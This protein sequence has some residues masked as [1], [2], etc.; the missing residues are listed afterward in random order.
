MQ[1]QGLR[2]GTSGLKGDDQA[3]CCSTCKGPCFRPAPHR[4]VGGWL[5]H[6]LRT[7]FAFSCWISV[8]PRS[9]PLTAESLRQLGTERRRRSS[10]R[11]S[12]DNSSGL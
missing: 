9:T 2:E 6:A 12:A 11:T 5:K 7:G 1:G 4:S 8:A 10:A 3:P